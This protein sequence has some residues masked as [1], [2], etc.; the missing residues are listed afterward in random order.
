MRDSKTRSCISKRAID[1]HHLQPALI[2]NE[3]DRP[4]RWIDG[5]ASPCYRAPDLGKSQGG[6]RYG[7]PPFHDAA[8][9]SE[10]FLTMDIARQEGRNPD[11]S[12]DDHHPRR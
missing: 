1:W 4:V 5:I 2:T 11:R 10:H 12:I 3:I 6:N 8:Q 7:F 9:E